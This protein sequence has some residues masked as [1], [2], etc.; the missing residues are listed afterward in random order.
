MRRFLA[1]LKE[2]VSPRDDLPS[3]CFALMPVPWCG[4]V[5]MG[6]FNTREEAAAKLSRYPDPENLGIYRMPGYRGRFWW[7][8]DG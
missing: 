2:K 1:W 6:V 3:D 4:S 7:E 5:V 8:F